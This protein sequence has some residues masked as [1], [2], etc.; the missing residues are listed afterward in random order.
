[1]RWIA[2]LFT[3]VVV[4]L[5][6]GC[7]LPLTGNSTAGGTGGVEAGAECP[8]TDGCESCTTCAAEGPCATANTT[9][10]NDSDCFAIASC[11]GSCGGDPTC[12]SSCESMSPNG[13]ADF[14][15][16]ATCLYCTQCSTAC[17]GQCP[18]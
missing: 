16:L 2:V 12:Q 15:A 6:V 4:V 3:S 7:N 17:A 1:M 14:Q 10:T 8:Q 13:V 18:S 11:W 5:V 9:C